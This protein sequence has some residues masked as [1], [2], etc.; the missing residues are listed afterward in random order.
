[1]NFIEM[2]DMTANASANASASA[3]ASASADAIAE[4]TLFEMVK[5]KKD[6][7]Y[8][9]LVIDALKIK[10][11]NAEECYSKVYGQTTIAKKRE[12]E[13]KQAQL[14]A[15]QIDKELFLQ[16]QKDKLDKL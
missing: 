1:M 9:E 4:A 8:Y 13:K 12:N 11:K 7:E 15:L 6:I 5:Y 2:N 10:Y 14:I 16:R 3:S